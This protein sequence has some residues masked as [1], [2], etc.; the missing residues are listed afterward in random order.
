MKEKEKT[1]KNDEPLYDYIIYTDGAYSQQHDEG[2]FAYV[3]LDGFGHFIKKKGAWKITGETNN[4]AELKAII[5]GLYHLPIDAQ[6][7]KVISDSQYALNTLSG[8]WGRNANQDLFKVFD[9]IMALHKYKVT[10]EW[11]KGHSGDE[12][13][14]MCDKMCNDKL[15]YD[16]NAEFD[17][18][19][20]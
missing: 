18:Y 19:R 20:K 3:M 12:Y 2:A 13:N 8:K 16:A 14:E 5:T 1:P 11:V 17:K 7:V 10:Y 15:G 4:R 9:D 6:Y